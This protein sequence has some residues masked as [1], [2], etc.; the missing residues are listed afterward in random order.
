[1]G[2][3]FLAIVAI[4]IGGFVSAV[5]PTTSKPGAQ[6]AAKL[7]GYGFMGLGIF[8]LIGNAFAG[9]PLHRAA[10]NAAVRLG[11]LRADRGR[12]AAD[13]VDRLGRRRLSA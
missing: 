2:S 1:M 10:G 12:R 5:G 6:G 9:L 3:I 11:G 4:L 13:A 8:W 7:A